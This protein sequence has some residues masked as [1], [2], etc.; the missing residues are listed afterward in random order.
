MGLSDLNPS[1]AIAPGP[2][3]YP[4]VGNLMD[5]RGDVLAVLLRSREFYGDVVRFRLGT[6]VLHLV[7][8]PEHIEHVLLTN[9]ENYDKE[10]RSS[11]KIRSVTGEGLLTSNGDFWLRQRRL[12]Q[13][14]F[15][16]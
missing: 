11:A 4:L 1:S 7:A 13:S 9:C 10:T 12:M 5:M 2:P 8:H 6:M 3:G 14:A 16:P 15:T